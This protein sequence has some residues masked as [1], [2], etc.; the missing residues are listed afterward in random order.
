MMD[1]S[2]T[3]YAPNYQFDTVTSRRVAS[4]FFLVS[5]RDN[6][7]C[8]VPSFP[9][10]SERNWMKKSARVSEKLVSPGLLGLQVAR[11]LTSAKLVQK[12]T[13]SN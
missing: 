2:V 5:P 3:D 13:C 6:F 4:Q 8:P 9:E 1:F 10:I 7:V 11:R 12:V